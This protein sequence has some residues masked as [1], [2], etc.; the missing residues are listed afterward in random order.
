[1]PI[2]WIYRDAVPDETAP[3]SLLST[4]TTLPD[5]VRDPP[6]PRQPLHLPIW[7]CSALPSPD[8]AQWPI[9]AVIVP[10][11]EYWAL[12]SL[13]SHGTQIYAVPDRCD[14]VDH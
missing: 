7:S 8:E 11:R 9:S 5:D 2:D 3:T 6:P 12:Q 10:I 13:G 4:G 14:L 1:M